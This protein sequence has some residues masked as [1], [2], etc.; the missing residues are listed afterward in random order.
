MCHLNAGTPLGRQKVTIFKRRFM[1]SGDSSGRAYGPGQRQQR[2][3]A[4]HAPNEPYGTGRLFAGPSLPVRDVRRTAI[5]TSVM[6]SNIILG[7]PKRQLTVM[8]K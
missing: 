8:E 6:M 5:N 4:R 2:P 7:K 1:S 3:F